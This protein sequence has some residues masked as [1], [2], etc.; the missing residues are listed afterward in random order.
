MSESSEHDRDHELGM[1][2]KITRRQFLDGV[3]I[4]VGGLALA[5]PAA[6]VLAGCGKKAKQP[7]RRPRSSATRPP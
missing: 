6:D 2:R 1:D 4:T 5:G 3:A 7:L